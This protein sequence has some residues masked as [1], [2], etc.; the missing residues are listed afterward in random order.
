MIRPSVTSFEA[1]GEPYR[2]AFEGKP[3]KM[4]FSFKIFSGSATAMTE[5]LDV[6]VA[7]AGNAGRSPY[8]TVSAERQKAPAVKNTA[9]AGIRKENISR[10]MAGRFRP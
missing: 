6:A 9:C 10:P 8:M 2:E 5:E 3:G 7:P 4:T 1:P